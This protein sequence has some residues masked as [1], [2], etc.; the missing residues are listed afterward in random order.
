M[1]EM[2]RNLKLTNLER[3]TLEKAF[4]VRLIDFSSLKVVW[5]LSNFFQFQTN[6][7]IYSGKPGKSFKFNCDKN[8]ISET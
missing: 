5:T 4:C 2:Y 1:M 6:L 3:S 7:K 8:V